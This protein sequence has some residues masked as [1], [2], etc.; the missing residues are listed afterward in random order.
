[1]KRG[2]AGWI[3]LLAAL[4]VLAAL[5]LAPIYFVASSSFKLPREIINRVPSWFP[6]SFTL[7]HYQKLLATS[8][9]PTYF[10]NSVLIASVSA[11]L[12][13][14]L[15]TL[16]GYAFF[17]LEFRGRDALYRAVMVAYAFPSIV[18]LIPIYLLFA[19]AGLID[20]RAALVIV[21]VTFA[22]PFSIWMM[23]TFFAS[24]PK[25]LEEAASIDGAGLAATAWY[26]LIPLLGPGLASIAIFAFVSAWTEY[27]F[28]SVLILSDAKRT[29]P[30]G[31]SGIIGQY[32][33]DWG[34][35]LAGATLSVVPV[36]VF[37]AFVGRWFVSGLT[38]GAVK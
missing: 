28:A 12:T 22:L 13:V 18:I 35:L 30:V 29:L 26:I 20:T 21:N 25:E 11:L 14:V 17:R 19:K 31:L 10:G 36:V 32:Q 8:D 37:F 38:E 7:Q 34:L 24:L 27:L 2:L 4:A 33:I 1:M 3:A 15:A 6:K 23:R 5:V 9:F 16:A